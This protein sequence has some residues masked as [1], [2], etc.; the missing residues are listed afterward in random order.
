MDFE[1]DIE[2]CLQVLRNGGLILYPTDT[3]WGI[4][5]DATNA[6]AVAKVYALKQR[7]DEKAMIVLVPEENDVLKY[8]ASVDLAL[9]DYLQEYPKPTTV[10]YDGAIGFADNLVAE[11]GSIA[12]RICGEPFCKQLLKRFR[13]PI[14]STSANI[15]GLPPAKN[16]A[17]ISEG[18][19]AGVDYVVQYRQ[20][21]VALAAPSS[22]IK[23][24]NGKLQIIRP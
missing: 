20:K 3:V 17:E 24:E 15:S 14:V 7:P 8:V 4:G 12:I 13:K 6:E 16:F 11:D 21:D 22:I 19:T 23:W 18:I 1:K 2:A 10:I 5:C 9:F